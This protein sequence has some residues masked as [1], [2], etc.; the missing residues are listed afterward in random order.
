MRPW[1]WGTDR[2]ETHCSDLGSF[3]V[4]HIHLDTLDRSILSLNVNCISDRIISN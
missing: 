4:H 2:P 3:L 1:Y